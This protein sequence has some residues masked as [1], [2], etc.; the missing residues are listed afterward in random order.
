MSELD[1]RKEVL[2]PTS[3][4]FSDDTIKSTTVASTMKQSVNYQGV[5][6]CD[7][8]YSTNGCEGFVILANKE[9]A[10]ALIKAIEKSIELG[11]FD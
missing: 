5:L 7:H 11:W 9:N 1:I 3:I 10:K 4:R 2:T 6:I 8:M